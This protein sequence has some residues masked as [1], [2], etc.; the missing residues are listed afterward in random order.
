MGRDKKEK[1]DSD[2]F[3]GETFGM[4]LILF[5][6]L[7]LVCLF[8]RDMVFSAVGRVVNGFL[9]GVFG[10]FAFPLFFWMIVMGVYLVC[11]KTLPISGKSRLFLYLA[12]VFSFLLVHAVT[13][14]S[15][16]GESYGAYLSAC[17]NAGEGGVSSATGGGCFFGLLDGLFLSLLTPVG[18]YVLL[19]VLIALTMYGFF[20]NLWMRGTSAVRVSREK[21]ARR[22]KEEKPSK[23]HSHTLIEED[24]EEDE[25]ETPA[26]P[27]LYYRDDNFELKTR[28]QQEKT[29]N[30]SFR[31]LY[32]NGDEGKSLGYSRESQQTYSAVYGDDMESKLNYIKTPSPLNLEDILSDKKKKRVGTQSVSAPKATAEVSAP[33][34]EIKTD[35]NQVLPPAFDYDDEPKSDTALRA[36]AFA[37]K[38]ASPIQSSVRKEEPIQPPIREEEPTPSFRTDSAP[39]REES[40]RLRRE[41]PAVEREEP[42]VTPVTPITPVRRDGESERRIFFEE[43]KTTDSVSSVEEVAND[44]TEELPEETNIPPMLRRREA[45]TPL[46]EPEKTEETDLA[47][48][49]GR[50]ERRI[51]ESTFV[52]SQDSADLTMEDKARA[53]IHRVYKRPPIDLFKIYKQDPNGQHENHEERSRIIERTLSEFNIDAKVVNCVQGPT[54]S[55]YEL[56]MPA[57]VPVKRVPNHAD[58]VAMR[59]ESENGVRV[60]APIPGKNLVG[61][62]VPNKVKQMVGLRDIIED[63]SFTKE[64]PGALTFALG[65]NIVGQAV[66]DNL[67][68]GPHYLV[69]GSTGMGKSVCLN[70]MIISLITKYS[71]EELRLIMVDPKQVEFNI[72]NHLPHLMIDEIITEPQKAIATLTWAIDEMEKRYTQFKDNEV[73]DIDEYNSCIASDSVP[74]MPKIVIIVDE[75]SDLMQYNKRDLE[76][77]ILSLS[78]KARAAGIHLVLATQRPSVDVI[79]GVIKTNLPSRIAF[80]VLSAADSMTILSE[81]GA[82][83]LLGNGDMLYRNSTMAKCER[84]QGAFIDTAEVKNIVNY[85]KENNEAYF[86]DDAAKSIEEAVRPPVVATEEESDDEQEDKLFVEAVRYAVLNNVASISMFQRRFKIGYGRAGGLIDSMERQGYVSPFQGSKAREVLITREQFE[87]KYGKIDE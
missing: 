32:P 84:I 86:D 51:P 12:V 74:K 34:R 58:D 62:E 40:F 8:T 7:A 75:V 1:R 17:Y 11:G 77:K 27:Q 36:D 4:V 79:T 83:K 13:S 3:S 68:K 25:P 52:E 26:G 64:K 28:R 16:I 59:L 15:M 43:E 85:I 38:Y 47:A 63:P 72:Y 45:S 54:V 44:T 56:M 22:A 50:R 23:T 33:V 82:E 87:E 24:A 65:K 14:A 20:R 46:I 35:R 80:R 21:R 70:T 53:M 49:I 31:I 42:P 30:D 18:S 81:G 57:G 37:E 78:Q 6:T 9:F 60:E 2:V 10:W 61:I 69:A 76:A 29:K 5:S 67:A 66:C 55:R 48:S 71:P 39:R 19:S 41:E 73:R